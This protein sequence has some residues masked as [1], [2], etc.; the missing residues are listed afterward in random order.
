MFIQTHASILLYFRSISRISILSNSIIYLLVIFI[1]GCHHSKLLELY[2]PAT[3][4]ASWLNF[5]ENVLK[6]NLYSFLG[7]IKFIFH[8]FETNNRN[9]T[10]PTH[11]NWS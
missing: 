1:L 7:F 3:R 10:S 8:L 9:C 6:I 5:V 4:D 11:C 2:M